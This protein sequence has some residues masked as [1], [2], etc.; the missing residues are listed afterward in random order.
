MWIFLWRI[1]FAARLIYSAVELR[2]NSCA[3]TQTDLQYRGTCPKG[4]I[5]MHA[6]RGPSASA[7]A[8]SRRDV[9]HVIKRE[10][11]DERSRLGII[12][13]RHVPRGCTQAERWQSSLSRLHRLKQPSCP[14]MRR[15]RCR[16]S[17][18]ASLPI[19]VP[20]PP[21]KLSRNLTRHFQWTKP[22]DQIT[23]P[24]RADRIGRH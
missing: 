23:P 10:K 19:F 4:C 17:R 9:D 21:T 14:L 24:R 3:R 22:L 13:S 8:R 1:S 11:P 18:D 5:L 2:A 7:S 15:P 6:C 20:D 12:T 16:V